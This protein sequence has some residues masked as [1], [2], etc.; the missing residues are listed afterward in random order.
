MVGQALLC[1]QR[2]GMTPVSSCDFVRVPQP[3]FV[4]SNDSLAAILCDVT[5]PQGAGDIAFSYQY[6]GRHLALKAVR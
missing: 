4:L 6:A 5:G 3:N 1:N 2:S